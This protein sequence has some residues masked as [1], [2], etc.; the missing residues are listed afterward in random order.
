M[1][2]H[3]PEG[4]IHPALTALMSREAPEDAQGEL[5]GGISSLQSISMVFGTVLFSQI[6]GH[7]TREDAVF[8]STGM[9]FYVSAALI[10]LTLAVFL[11][12]RRA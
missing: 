6:F 8:R 9:A 4:F 2:V 11:L 5:Q 10:A 12:R 1:L 7:F 3:A